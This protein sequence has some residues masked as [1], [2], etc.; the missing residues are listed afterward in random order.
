MRTPTTGATWGTP[1]VMVF[2]VPMLTRL[3][4]GGASPG[5][6]TFTV[7]L[8]PMAKVPGGGASPIPR[9]IFYSAAAAPVETPPTLIFTLSSVVE[10]VLAVAVAVHTR[11]PRRATKNNVELAMLAIAYYM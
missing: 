9:S 5:T 7:P 10:S 8:T 4:G 1:T 2:F 3:L 6:P 11:T